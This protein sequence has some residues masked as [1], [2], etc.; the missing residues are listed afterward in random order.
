MGQG[1]ERRRR[2]RRARVLSAAGAPEGSQGQVRAER[3]RC[4]WITNKK[5]ASPGG[6]TDT[7][8]RFCRPSR[9]VLLFSNVP[10]AAYS[11]RSHLPLATI[12]RACGAQNLATIYRA[13]GAQNP[14]Y[15]LPRLRRS[16]P[17]LPSTAPAALRTLA[18]ICRAC[19]A[20]NLATI[21]RACGAQNPGYH[22]PRLRRSEPGYHLPRLRRSEPGYHLPRLRRTEPGYHLPRLRRSE[23][24]LPSAAPAALRPR[25]RKESSTCSLCQLPTAV[26]PPFRPL[27]P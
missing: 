6:A 9:P 15:H 3:A 7:L 21:C 25:N 4:P 20:Q 18:T 2:A 10:G 11:L 24:W 19:G 17:W 5:R 16:E 8:A 14:G 1:H 27:F 13:C 26:E 12:Y 22:L 23:P